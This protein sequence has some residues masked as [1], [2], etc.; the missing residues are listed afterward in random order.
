MRSMTRFV[1]PPWA[2]PA[3]E[4]YVRSVSQTGT[5]SARTVDAYRTDVAQFLTLCDS[6]DRRRLAD[7]SHSDMSRYLVHLHD[8]GYARSTVARKINALRS[9]FDAL[10]RAGTISVNPAREVVL[11]KQ[12]R[13]LPTVLSRRALIDAIESIDGADPVSLRDR[14]IV[15]LLYATGIRVSELAGLSAGGV[16]RR[17]MI[18]VMG[19][20]AKERTVPMGIPAQEAVTRW[21][22]HGRPALT[23]RESAGALFLGVRGKPIHVRQIRRVVGQ[24]LGATPHALRH[25]F[26][27]HMMEGGADIRSIQ[28]LLGHTNVD[29]TQIYTAVSA[30]HIR[31]VHKRSHPRA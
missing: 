14:A 2:A 5:L 31:T 13:P 23:T 21:V 9:F 28:E 3:A 7:L 27:T 29:S 26:A 20:G 4:A 1:F 8:K 30:G 15:E 22:D 25:S 12:K 18:V 19:K 24:R 6:W 10:H 11:P 17:D 16:Y